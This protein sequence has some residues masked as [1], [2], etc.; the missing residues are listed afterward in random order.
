MLVAK[1]CLC[2][3]K[4]VSLCVCF[5]VWTVSELCLCLNCVCLYCWTPVSKEFLIYKINTYV[6]NTFYILARKTLNSNNLIKIIRKI[7]NLVLN[8]IFNAQ[9][10][11][12]KRINTLFLQISRQIAKHV[13]SKQTIIDE[14]PQLWPYYYFELFFTKLYYNVFLLNS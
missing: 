4:C 8:Y 11:C 2:V 1:L 7:Q 14:T 9:I 5:C 3:S 10:N 6:I 12:L 13:I